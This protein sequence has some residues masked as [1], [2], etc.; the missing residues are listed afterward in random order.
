MCPGRVVHS[1]CRTGTSSRNVDL[2]TRSAPE[3]QGVGSYYSVGI[4]S[5]AAGRAAPVGVAPDLLLARVEPEGAA[6][7]GRPLPF[8]RRPGVAVAQERVTSPSAISLPAA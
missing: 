2:R 5:S 6:S 7:R 4:Y 8:G 1:M 3:A